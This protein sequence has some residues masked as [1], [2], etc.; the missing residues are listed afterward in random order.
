MKQS[1][2]AIIIFISLALT[3][4]AT[5]NAGIA[6]SNIPIVD[7]KYKVVQAVNKTDY[8][9]TIDIG[10]LGFPLS[11]PPIDGLMNE[12][13]QESNADAL[14]NIRYW[15]DRTILL[16]I[17]VNRIGLAADAVQFESEPAP[18]VTNPR[19]R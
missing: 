12:A 3:H 5:S 11:E 1:F 8:W 9:I 18:P 4:C 14:V 2:F 16:F 10:I 15:S 6:T 7:K 17:T 13:I 19:R